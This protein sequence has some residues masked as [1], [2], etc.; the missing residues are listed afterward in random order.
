MS[1]ASKESHEHHGPRGEPRYCPHC[2]TG[3]ERRRK[4]G[5]EFPVCPG[6][7]FVHYPD[8]KVAI[9]AVVQNAA[10][11]LL[12]VQRR[13]APEKGKWG[14]PGGFLDAG[15]DPK[16]AAEREALEETGLVVEA[17]ELLDVLHNREPGGA[18]IVILYRAT[19]KGGALEADDDA[20]DARYFALDA[21][22][23]LAFESTANAVERLTP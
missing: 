7:R 14:L 10:G 11:A 18:S 2:G 15:E 5:R 16:R 20:A 4:K 19:A 3:L 9:A 13:F 17:S 21:L 1:D 8:P 22:P 12:L 23:E 6:C